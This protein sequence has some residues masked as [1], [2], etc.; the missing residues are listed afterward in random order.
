MLESA[1]SQLEKERITGWNVQ[2]D[3][4]RHSHDGAEEVTRLGRYNIYTVFRGISKYRWSLSRLLSLSLSRLGVLG[5]RRHWAGQQLTRGWAVRCCV[6]CVTFS[7]NPNF[8]PPP[9][10]PPSS[11]SLLL[12]PS[13]HH[14]LPSSS[15][16]SPT[17][18]PLSSAGMEDRPQMDVLWGDRGKSE[19][20]ALW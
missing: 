20:E 8:L 5:R 15:S 18:P 2:T 16:S 7:S 10:H 19:G 6:S 3:R 17:S 12:H 11:T 1:D 14:L 13:S 4:Y 9:P